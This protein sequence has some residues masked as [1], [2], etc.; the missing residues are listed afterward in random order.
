MNHKEEA[1]DRIVSSLMSEPN[2]W[3]PEDLCRA[4][5]APSP[6]LDGQPLRGIPFGS[7]LR[8]AHRGETRF[9]FSGAQVE[10]RQNPAAL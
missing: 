7:A 2:S 6:L 9:R 8:L 10:M 4:H 5:P 3:G 1:Q